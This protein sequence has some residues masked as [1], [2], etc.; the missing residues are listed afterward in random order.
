MYVNNTD[1]KYVI[2][3]K[4]ACFAAISLFLKHRFKKHKKC[5]MQSSI[6]DINNHET[7]IQSERTSK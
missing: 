5:L 6:F 4:D 1:N 2:Y 7:N 3:A